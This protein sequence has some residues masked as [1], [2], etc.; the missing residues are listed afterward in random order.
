MKKILMIG[1]ILFGLIMPGC[2]QTK[3]NATVDKNGNFVAIKNVLDTIPKATGKTYTDS[4]GNVFPISVSPNGKYFIIRVS[5]KT[6][7]AYRQ[8]LR[9]APNPNKIVVKASN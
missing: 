3:P 9:V 6:G 4:K 1:M 5:K 2:A 7:K 8:Y